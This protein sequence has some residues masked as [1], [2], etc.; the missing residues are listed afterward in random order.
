MGWQINLVKNTVEVPEDYA[1]A[2]YEAAEEHFPYGPEEVLD[3]G[4][5]TFDDDASE[6]MDYLH[7]DSVL[8]VL[9]E[10]KVNGSIVFSSNEGDNRSTWW[11]YDFTDGE[12]SHRDGKLKD[13]IPD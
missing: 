1:E 6:H 11:A 2:L 5:L 7:D 3:E 4:L 13:L 8:A 9:K 10:A 12:V